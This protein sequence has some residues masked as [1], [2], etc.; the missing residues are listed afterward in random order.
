MK[1]YA[2]YLGGYAPGCNVEVH[3]MV[4]VTGKTFEDTWPSL[5][6]KWFL[7][8]YDRFHYDG[9]QELR[10]VDNHRIRLISSKSKSDLKLYYVHLG[11]YNPDEL[12]EYHKN[13]FLVASDKTQAKKRARESWTTVE[14]PH[15]D[16]QC[17]IEAC[18]EINEIDNLYL[19]IQPTNE[20]P[21]IDLHLGY[22][23][24]PEEV[25]RKY[26]PSD[27]K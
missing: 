25:T 23:R 9:Y 3:D 8:H 12:N 22:N 19:D 14:V 2:V 6:Q 11:G 26:A 10:I 20:K 24:F 16:L 5:F 4:F 21:V 27:S 13:M 7:K 1:L 18:I 15:K 17:D